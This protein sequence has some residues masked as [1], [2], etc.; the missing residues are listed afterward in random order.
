MITR[1]VLGRYRSALDFNLGQIEKDYLQHLTLSILYRTT[2]D[3]FVFKGGTCLQ[4]IYGL[5]RF[6]ED[7]DFT[8][9]KPLDVEKITEEITNGISNFGYQTKNRFLEKGRSIKIRFEVQGPL[10]RESKMSVCYLTIEASKREQ[11]ILEPDFKMVYPFY[12]D[13]PPYSTLSMKLEEMLA[14][15]IRALVMRRRARDLYDL[16][17]LLKKKT[18][19]K[20]NLVEKKMIYYDRAV[21]LDDIINSIRE[22]KDIWK[23][24][25]TVLTPNLPDFEDVESFVINRAKKDWGGKN[26][27]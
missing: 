25:L 2:A 17:F 20:W 21:S 5:D 6:S 26:T 12:E 10:Y 11:V 14:E 9:Y 24:E 16:Y 19:I 4:K 27:K 1:D 23:R 8:I 18:A 22:K 13:L 3:S 7:L 15:K